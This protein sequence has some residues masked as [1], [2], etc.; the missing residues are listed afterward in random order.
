M[1]YVSLLPNTVHDHFH[2]DAAKGLVGKQVPFR[3]RSGGLAD[4]MAVVVGARVDDDGLHLELDL[5]AAAGDGEVLSN[6]AVYGTPH[7]PSEVVPVA[8]AFSLGFH[9]GVAEIDP[10]L[11]VGCVQPSGI[12]DTQESRD[13]LREIVRAAVRLHEEGPD[14]P[15]TG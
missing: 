5:P 8:P 15:S 13:A 11:R 1:R 2:P 14:A 4:T 12:L 6:L 10:L 7:G 9:T 3:N